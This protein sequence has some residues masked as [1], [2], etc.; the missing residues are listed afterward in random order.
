MDVVVVGGA[1]MDLVSFVP[2]LPHLGETLLGHSFMTCHGGKGANQ[3]VQAAKLVKDA[4]AVGVIAKL[5][6]D[7]NGKEIRESWERI[8]MDRS[9][10]LTTTESHTAVA[11]ICVTDDGANAIVVV[12]GAAALLS[13]EDLH[14][15]PIKQL[16][17][18]AK[19]VVGQLEIPPEITLEAFKIA[20][21]S[22][23]SV[24]TILN[25]APAPEKLLEGFFA[26]T[27]LLCVNQEEAATLSRLPCSILAEAK[28]ACEALLDAEGPC[29]TM[30]VVITLGKDGC[31]AAERFNG[32]GPILTTHVAT[33]K[34][35][36]EQI[37]DTTGA[38]DS[39]VGALAVLIAR[40]AKLVDACEK[41]CVVAG[42]SVKSK[43]AQ[44]GYVGRDQ[45]PASVTNAL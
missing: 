40:G 35:P 17:A 42:E 4:S 36:P 8:G 31:M 32:T 30:Q 27:T 24:T 43:G 14:T 16:L 45:L 28:E 7:A 6:D 1:N 21:A 3:A 37:V 33:P 20:R 15:P 25:A 34:I 19:V 38:G 39:F 9:G 41:A 5:G 10:V 29:P 26:N 22:N 11:P 2:R 13:I 23:P 12:P 18:Q 44:G